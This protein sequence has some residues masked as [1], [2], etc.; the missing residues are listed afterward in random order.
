MFLLSE[1][2][3]Q[4]NYT[5]KDKVRG[6]TGKYSANMDWLSLIMQVSIFSKM[7]IYSDKQITLISV[8]LVCSTNIAMKKS[9]PR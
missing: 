1:I 7:F 9:I 3:D 4:R 2:I 5:K 6:E 8:L